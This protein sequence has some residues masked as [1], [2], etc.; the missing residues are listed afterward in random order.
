MVLVP[1]T[2]CD[3]AL[4]A[5]VAVPD[6]ARVLDMVRG[7]SLPEAAEQVLGAV[8]MGER[9]HLVGFSLGAIVAF[10]VL[11]W[12]PER[13]ARLTLISA[14]P[15]A[16]TPAQLET[17]AAH[18]E[19]VRAG[20]FEKLAGTL[21][22]GAG[23]HHGAVLDMARRLGPE[24]YLEQLGLLCSRPDSRPDV[25]GFT[26]PLTLLGG[27]DD[28]VTPPRLTEELQALAPHATVRV[29]PGAGH[30]LPLDAPDTVSSVLNAVI[31][32]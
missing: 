15:H 6:G 26:G 30:Y 24:V 1:G 28:R 4:W 8:P 12:A 5:G 22:E 14:N 32:A 10:E 23:T 9:L 20:Q 31:H 29:V 25:A 18:E 13:L 27:G 21:T 17:W 11:R 7:R 16:P 2:L 19:Q 3:G